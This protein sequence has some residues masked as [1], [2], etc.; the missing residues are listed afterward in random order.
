MSDALERQFLQGG[1]GGSDETPQ[2]AQRRQAELSGSDDEPDVVATPTDPA[3]GLAREN[4]PQT[5]PKGVIADYRHHTSTQQAQRA[6]RQRQETQRMASTYRRE[7]PALSSTITTQTEPKSRLSHSH[8]FKSPKPEDSEDEELD[9][10]LNDE[11]LTQYQQQR[12]DEWRHQHM[13]SVDELTAADY[14]SIID[15]VAADVR[16]VVHVYE[17]S[18]PEC[19][20]LNALLP[21]VAQQTAP[22]RFVKI[23][24]RETGQASFTPDM[25]P[26][27]VAYQNGAL[28]GT[29]IRATDELLSGHFEVTDVIN[30]LQR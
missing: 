11:F 19:R 1:G 16:V 23:R 12:M 27:L 14:A 15:Q 20:R 18:V 24:A 21:A 22:S 30:L 17:D 13:G 5:G 7:A 25:L 8:T 4:G 29:I 3:A 28:V 26:I 9:A 6:E 10:L 2:E